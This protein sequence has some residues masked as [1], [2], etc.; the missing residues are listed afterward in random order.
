LG[1][2]GFKYENGDGVLVKIGGNSFEAIVNFY[3]E[4]AKLYEVKWAHY[5]GYYDV[6][7]KDMKPLKQQL[8]I[9][10]SADSELNTNDMKIAGVIPFTDDL[11]I[12]SSPITPSSFETPSRLHKFSNHATQAK[13]ELGCIRPEYA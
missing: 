9:M 11:L 13:G 6:S 1:K 5:R 12:H 2:S 7:S 10:P 3:D 8:A 4:E